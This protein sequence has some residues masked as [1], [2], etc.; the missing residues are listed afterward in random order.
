MKKTIDEFGGVD[1]LVNN[2]GISGGGRILSEVRDDDF[3]TVF[4]T[5]FGGFLTC[6][7]AVIPNMMEKR[8]GKDCIYL[9]GRGSWGSLSFRL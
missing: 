1:I 7:Q 5:N 9:F 3:D 2:A 8:Y 6:N 4:K